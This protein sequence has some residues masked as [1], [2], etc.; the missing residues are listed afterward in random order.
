MR[1]KGKPKITLTLRLYPEDA[2]QIL[3]G[4]YKQ[5]KISEGQLLEKSDKALAMLDISE[6][7]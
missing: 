1:I 4:L 6:I 2:L 7:M 3:N 5:G